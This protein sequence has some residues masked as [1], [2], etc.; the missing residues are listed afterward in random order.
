MQ[1]GE[2]TCLQSQSQYEQSTGLTIPSS[3]HT[4]ERKGFFPSD[5]MRKRR[6]REAKELVQ[7]HTA[8]EE[9]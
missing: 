3:R 5:P 1:R 7:G 9:G 4:W 6:L 8:S 2:G